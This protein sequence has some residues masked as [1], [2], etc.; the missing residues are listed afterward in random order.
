MTAPARRTGG[1]SAAVLT[2]IRA[3]VEDLVRERG[4]ERVTIPLVA[5]RA[6]V[7]PTSI[8]R[9]WGDAATMI[10]DIA[11]YRL[12]P[13]R[14]LPSTGSLRE[15]LTA[16]AAEI[17]AHYRKPVNAALLRA[18]VA[19][20]G[21]GPSDCLRNRRLEAGQLVTDSAVTVEEVIDT[22]IAPI[23]YRVIF[24]P[25]TLDDDTAA[26]LVDRLLPA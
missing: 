13:S 23:V 10:N 18:G 20:A 21:E 24:L 5:E 11:T 26:R 1:R 22:V 14:P 2:S 25:E 4:A 7:N 9:R 19:V 16:W 12:D 3:A 8:Y 17:V 15:D 6:G